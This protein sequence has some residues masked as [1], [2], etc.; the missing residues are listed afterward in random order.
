MKKRRTRGQSLIEFILTLLAFLTVLFMVV[1]VGLSFGIANYVHYATYMAARA[2]L[3]GDETPRKQQDN[4]KFVLT[5]MLKRE[6]GEDRFK[7]VI[8]GSG[9]G[10][11]IGVDLIG[12]SP[13]VN[14]NDARQTTWEQGVVYRYKAKLYM[15]PLVR[16][17]K[18]GVDN[19]V[20]LESETWLGRDPSTQ[21]CLTQLKGRSRV[22]PW[23]V[24]NG[25]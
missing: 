23:I 3:S 25:C 11:P 22:D 8:H 24:D 17:A 19:S 1:Q 13:R 7:P 10:D 15:M 4:A 20:E 12:P 6:G 18:R 16:G 5:S 14:P 2:L 9:S 21:E